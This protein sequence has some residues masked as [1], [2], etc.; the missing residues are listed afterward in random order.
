MHVVCDEA[1]HSLIEATVD[2][3]F[4]GTARAETALPVFAETTSSFLADHWVVLS[5]STCWQSRDQGYAG[6]A[7]F[8]GIDFYVCIISDKEIML[9]DVVVYREDLLLVN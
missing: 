9:I 3:L 2:L 6:T 5:P 7:A 4:D 1:L 8:A